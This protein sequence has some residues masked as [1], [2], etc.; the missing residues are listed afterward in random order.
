[1]CRNEYSLF[2][3]NGYD[4]AY[5]L[6]QYQTCKKVLIPQFLVLG[7]G[8]IG[9]SHNKNQTSAWLLL[10][11]PERLLR[12]EG[13]ER[14]RGKRN[15]EVYYSHHGR[16]NKQWPQ[17]I[18]NRSYLVIVACGFAIVYPIKFATQLLTYIIWA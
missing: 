11:L 17:Q 12:S 10:R 9:N 6:R 3:D 16:V 4:C 14:A 15:R 5:Y 13:S 8:F 7:F 2:L 18:G 1:M